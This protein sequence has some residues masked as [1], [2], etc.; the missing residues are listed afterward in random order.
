[1]CC[2]QIG[3][4]LAYSICKNS[5]SFESALPHAVYRVKCTSHS[6]NSRWFGARAAVASRQAVYIAEPFKC[7]HCSCNL[8]EQPSP[9]APVSAAVQCLVVTSFARRACRARCVPSGVDESGAGRDRAH[10][11]KLRWSPQHCQLSAPVVLLLA[12]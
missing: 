7:I 2:T 8:E 1:M 12:P 5:D 3:S 4:S 6:S 9:R 10:T 11:G